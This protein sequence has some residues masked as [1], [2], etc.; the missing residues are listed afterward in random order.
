MCVCVYMY[1]SDLIDQIESNHK[2]AVGGLFTSKNN[3]VKAWKFV[4]VD[5]GQIN[6]W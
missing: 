5:N 6:Y 2:P 3:S 1:A 4:T